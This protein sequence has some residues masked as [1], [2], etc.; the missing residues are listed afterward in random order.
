[1]RKGITGLAAGFIAGTVL[2]GSAAFAIGI[3]SPAAGDRNVGTTAIG[4]GSPAIV[5]AM[6]SSP[7]VDATHTGPRYTTIAQA[8]S[9]QH[10]AER[11]AAAAHKAA[12]A[13]A[14]HKAA[15]AHRAAEARTVDHV[16]QA[17]RRAVASDP[18]H[19]SDANRGT[20][21]APTPRQAEP[22]HRVQSSTGGH[23]MESGHD[24]MSHE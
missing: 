2:A 16:A 17:P 18:A 8:Q 10:E 6:N 14:A 20:V 1:M 5:R 3:A 7:S 22:T 19:D 13:A 12:A 9:A 24:G 4:T 21:C 23:D 15:E 11:T